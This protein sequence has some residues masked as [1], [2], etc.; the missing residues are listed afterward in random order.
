MHGSAQR[1]PFIDGLAKRAGSFYLDLLKATHVST[2]EVLDHPA[3]AGGDPAPL[4]AIVRHL[5]ILQLQWRQ[6][7]RFCERMPQTLVHGDLGSQNARIRLGHTSNSLLIMDW[8]KAGWGVPAVDL[9][10]SVGTSVSPDIITYWSAVRSYWP[11]LEM[12]DVLRLAEY[13]TMFRLL[14]AVEWVNQGF[15]TWGNAHTN[16]DS[17]DWYVSELQCYEA[18]LAN[19]IAAH[20]FDG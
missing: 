17:P 1:V 3:F 9:A 2:L 8:E 5:S 4:D 16:W 20:A 15:F 12:T 7:E 6:V 10:Q 13:G 14:N 11:V 19:W 18:A